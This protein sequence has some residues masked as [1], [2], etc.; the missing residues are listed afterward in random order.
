ME[1]TLADDKLRAYTLT[2]SSLTR[3]RSVLCRGPSESIR[4]FLDYYDRAVR[5]ISSSS[6]SVMNQSNSYTQQDLWAALREPHTHSLCTV[7]VPHTEKL[8]Y[9]LTFS[10]M[11]LRVSKW[12]SYASIPVQADVV[13][14]AMNGGGRLFFRM[15]VNRMAKK[16][17]AKCLTGLRNVSL[18]NNEM[19]QK[20]NKNNACKPIAFRC[21]HAD[22]AL[23]SLF[24][25]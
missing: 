24:S 1:C 9:T 11:R 25:N 17:L 7:G 12:D 4:H 21:V 16:K 19:T 18:P 5:W 23:G 10:W 20:G 13:V 2:R 15:E 6:S 8:R 22:A 3:M 14:V